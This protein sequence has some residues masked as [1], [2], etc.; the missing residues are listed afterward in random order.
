MSI[1]DSTY[2]SPRDKKLNNTPRYDEK[3]GRTFKTFYDQV[4]FWN[5]VRNIMDDGYDER[6]AVARAKRF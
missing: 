1:H 3:A 5:T 2:I 4:H 6:E